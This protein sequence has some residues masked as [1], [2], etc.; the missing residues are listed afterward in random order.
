MK[1]LR[2]TAAAISAGLIL[3]QNTL[4]FAAPMSLSLQESINLALQNNPSIQIV[5]KDKEQSEWG[6]SEAKA[7]RMPTVSLGSNYNF[8][9]GGQNSNS[10][11]M[12]W[13]V[14]SGG[15]TDAKI[16]QAELGVV[17]ADLDLEKTKQQVIL[18]TT[19]DYYNVLEAKNMVEVNEQTV[20][21]LT[22]HLN[23]VQ[24]KYDAGVVAKVDL[25]RSEVELA[26]AKQNLIKAQN[27]YELAVTELLNTINIDADTELNLDGELAYQA[28]QRTLAD[29]IDQAKQN[30][31]EIAKAKISIESAEQGIK[32]AKSGKLPSISM[33]ASTGWNDSLLPDSSNDWSVGLSASWNVFDAGVTKAQT[34]QAKASLDKVKLQAE[35][36]QDVVEQEVRE[37]YL[38]MKEAEKRLE[39][40]E[41]TV[42]KA[43]EDL[44]I[45]QERYKAGV[46]TNLDLIDAQ[47]ALTQA[48]TNHIQALYDYN[49]NKAKL[50]KATGVK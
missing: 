31:P 13:Q 33:S 21:N 50:D 36:T 6:V 37:S 46:G 1:K 8:Q 19:T 7:G 44:Y 25:L 41:V 32:A 34:N 4:S 16:N 9:N 20:N 45:A 24:A 22:A 29:A 15:R 27:Q 14:Y 17:G 23:I 40:T 48:K 5:G 18:D 30:R 38:G 49:V 47:L 26:N 12:N 3:L 11:R 35:Q 42:N 10:L 28:D 39:T 2:V 43:N